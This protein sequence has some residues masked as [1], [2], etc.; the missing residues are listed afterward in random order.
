MSAMD[1]STFSSLMTVVMLAVFLGIVAW[2][3]SSRRRA[4]FDEAARVPFEEDAPVCQPNSNR[5]G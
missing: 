3:C 2:A 5:H 4:A 1:Y